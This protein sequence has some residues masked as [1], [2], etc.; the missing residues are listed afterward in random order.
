MSGIWKMPEPARWQRALSRVC[1]ATILAAGSG[2]FQR[3][4][5]ELRQDAPNRHAARIRT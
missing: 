1:G 4:L 5:P 3:R 2:G